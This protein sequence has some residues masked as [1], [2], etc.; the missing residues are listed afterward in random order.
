MSAGI[1]LHVDNVGNEIDNTGP[2][3]APPLELSDDQAARARSFIES[4]LRRKLRRQ[5]ADTEA[6]RDVGA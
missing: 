5:L 3:P 4:C 2:R 6:L 1:Q